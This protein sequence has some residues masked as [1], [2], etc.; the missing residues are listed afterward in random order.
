VPEVF[1]AVE[2]EHYG[3]DDGL[4]AEQRETVGSRDV[5]AVVGRKPRAVFGSQHN[6]FDG[7]LSIQYLL[8]FHTHRFCIGPAC[9]IDPGC[10][11]C[12]IILVVTVDDFEFMCLV[13]ERG[14]GI[15]FKFREG[16]F[17][18]AQSLADQTG[19]KVNKDNRKRFLGFTLSKWKI[20]TAMY[21]IS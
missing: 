16:V 18:F 5:E 1:P 12:P 19:I 7:A 3:S 6:P 11:K 20:L 17:H 10:R 15:C 21:A 2:V 4:A 8:L 14:E 13:I 9:G